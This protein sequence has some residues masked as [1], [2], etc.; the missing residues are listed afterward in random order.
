MAEE[1]RH[2]TIVGVYTHSENVVFILMLPQIVRV[3]FIS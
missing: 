1:L 3:T 2:A